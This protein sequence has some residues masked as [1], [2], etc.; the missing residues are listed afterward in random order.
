MQGVGKETELGYL[1]KKGVKMLNNEDLNN[2][3]NIYK[4]ELSYGKTHN[5]LGKINLSG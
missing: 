2:L 4:D 3:E 5:D 1:N